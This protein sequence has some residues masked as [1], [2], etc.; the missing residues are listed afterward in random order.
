MHYTVLI[1]RTNIVMK[2]FSAYFSATAAIALLTSSSPEILPILAQAKIVDVTVPILDAAAAVADA[3]IDA[4]GAKNATKAATASPAGPFS[5][6]GFCDGHVHELGFDNFHA[7]LN[8]SSF[9]CVL[10]Y[11]EHALKQQQ[12][13]A[14]AG[15]KKD[16]TQYGD[17]L[18]MYNV[19]QRVAAT[20]GKQQPTAFNMRNMRLSFGALNTRR[21]TYLRGMY[22]DEHATGEAFDDFYQNYEDLDESDG[23]LPE[24]MIS[25]ETFMKIPSAQLPTF[26]PRLLILHD[27]NVLSAIELDN[28]DVDVFQEASVIDWLLA[29]IKQNAHFVMTG[30]GA[31]PL[32]FGGNEKGPK[33]QLRSFVHEEERK[34]ENH[35]ANHAAIMASI[36]WT[37]ADEMME[38]RQNEPFSFAST[39]LFDISRDEAGD[40][41]YKYKFNTELDKESDAFLL[42]KLSDIMVSY[43]AYANSYENLWSDERRAAEDERT[44]YG[45]LLQRLDANIR[46]LVESAYADLPDEGDEEDGDFLPLVTWDDVPDLQDWF[47]DML[48]GFGRSPSSLHAYLKAHVFE[49]RKSVDDLQNLRLFQRVR[50]YMAVR[51]N[52]GT[53]D[54]EE[55]SSVGGGYGMFFRTLIIQMAALLA[56]F[57]EHLTRNY[58]TYLNEHPEE[59]INRYD[60]FLPVDTFDMKDP[61]NF[62]LLTDYDAFEEQY[63]A[64]RKPFRLSNVEMTKPFNYT[65]D[66]LVEQCGFMDV[67]EDTAQSR[68]LGNKDVTEWGKSFLR[69]LSITFGTCLTIII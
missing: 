24:G 40:S 63:V 20:F 10:F 42:G 38:K 60:G 53:D 39:K 19:L 26:P 50:E 43:L 58:L 30:P 27:F 28:V 14:I 6:T 59:M 15:K 66:F 47:E 3:L 37:V 21:H 16:E 64:K 18:R 68:S 52:C 9:S 5:S 33:V 61:K 11:D 67:T 35:V 54:D 69:E 36:N 1:N 44:G 51:E 13:A 55:G 57:Q 29:K 49:T 34:R 65:M 23:D 8:S 17:T 4:V 12:A 56:E 7:I 31:E 25:S 62:D 22:L 48:F 41:F 45:P 46:N 32:P 2:A